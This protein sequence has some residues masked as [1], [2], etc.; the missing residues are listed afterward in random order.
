MILINVV[1]IVVGVKGG[2]GGLE[3]GKANHTFDPCFRD[4]FL[5]E[6]LKNEIKI[7]D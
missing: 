4:L 7:N 3:E 1:K 5:D 6:T 2:E